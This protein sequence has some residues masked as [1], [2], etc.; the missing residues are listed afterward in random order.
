MSS[1]QDQSARP[2]SQRLERLNAL[3]G[4][5]ALLVVL[6][7]VRQIALRDMG[8]AGSFEFWHF[9]HAGVDLFFVISGFVIY[10][11]HRRDIGRPSAVRRFL[12][13]RLVRVYPPLWIVT[14]G[15]LLGALVTAHAVHAEKMNVWFIVRSYLLWPIQGALPL[16]PPAWT[17]SHEVK[18][19][20]LFVLAIAL[21][22][23]VW[24]PVLATVF[25][26]SV[27]A[28]II[29]AVAPTA[30]PF[31]ISFLFSPYNLEFA[32]G[33][34]IAAFVLDRGVV[35]P[36]LWGAAGLVAWAVAAAHDQSLVAPDVTQVV[37]Y[38]VPSGLIVLAVAARDLQ[39]PAFD[40]PLLGFFGDASHAVYLVHLPV[41]IVAIRIAKA[42]GMG[43]TTLM[44]LGVAAIATAAGLIFHI[45]AERPITRYLTGRFAAKPRSA[46]TLRVA[47]NRAGGS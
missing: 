39:R 28:G 19:Y 45:V 10:L 32:A 46:A 40:A 18:F 4:P 27:V 47:G 29:E 7:H 24:K 2:R 5:A 35:A 16:L 37:R 34:A 9:G 21:P 15:V 33:A 26:G 41:I 17:L 1:D 44:L 6:Y 8:S 11:V 23:R 30:L 43:P 22:R 42:L 25:I 3:R 31:A 13:R 20:L 36:W 14:T 38:G 12:M